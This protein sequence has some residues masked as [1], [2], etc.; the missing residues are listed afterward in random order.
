MNSIFDMFSIGVGPS[1][2][3]T[4]G[5]MNAAV[6][7][8]EDLNLDSVSKV[9]VHLFGSLSLTGK[10]HGTDNA[11]LC[12]LMGFKADTVNIDLYR[13]ITTHINKTGH[14]TLNNTHTIPFNIDSDL[15]WDKHFH[16]GH[17][18]TVSFMAFDD[19][20]TPI[21]TRTFHSIGGGFITEE[22]QP[23]IHTRTPKHAFTTGQDLLDICTNR[24]N[25]IADIVY[26]NEKEW[27]TEAEIKHALLEIWTVMKDAIQN[28]I[29]T[30]GE[31]PGG[32]HVQRRAKDLYDQFKDTASE[33]TSMTA[34]LDH[35]STYAIA[36]NEEN[37]AG[38]RI[39][40]APTNGASGVI[41]SVLYYVDQCITP[42][43]YE[44]ILTFFMTAG[45]IC[46]LFKENASISGAEMG[47]QGEVGVASAM[48]AAGLT[49]L[50][51]GTPH[52]I[53]CAAEIAMEHH[54]GLTCDPIKG[55]VQVPCI[56]RNSMG[57]IKAVTACELALKR[58]QGFR[59]ISLDKVIRTMK[60]TGEDMN[61]AYK[62][63][64][65]GGL[66]VEC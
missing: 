59:K 36:V 16:S 22:N 55:L 8:V 18:N 61:R 32:L 52:Q 54:L 42:L 3:H 5:P 62:E 31:L 13:S 10:G 53:E 23:T 12:G 63:T 49:A 43:T 51:G 44:D 47:C 21:S 11:V 56:E 39:V 6:K 14:L 4:V 37:A 46:H 27:K 28:G 20:N 30:E 9:S 17:A 64:A 40:T 2:S 25:S 60:R 34:L 66:A 48:A 58:T 29:S 24:S 57:A 33:A 26:E 41:P 45:G 38:G 65:L 35:L 15:I 7:F 1:S 50:K 19:T